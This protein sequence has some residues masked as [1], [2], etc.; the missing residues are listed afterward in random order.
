MLKPD[1]RSSWV[2]LALAA[3]F[4]PFG[5]ARFAR[6]DVSF[7]RDIRPILSENCFACHGHDDQKRKANLRLD[8][9][10]TATRPAKSGAIAIVPGKLDESELVKRITAT[11]PDDRM[12]PADSNKHLT[13]A[14]IETLKQWIAQGAKYQTHWAFVP[15][16]R[17][18]LPAISDPAWSGN[19]IDRLIRARLDAE[20]LK[21]SPQAD[22]V[23]LLRRVYLDLIG[24]PPTVKEIDEH[25]RDTSPD[26][27]DR[28]V[29]KLLA[30]PHYGERM[31]RDWLDAARYADTD[32]FEKDKPRFIWF[33]RDWVINA[34]NRDLPY[35]KF[36]IEQ[37]AGDQL[38]HPMQDQI[39]ATGFL[40]N[41]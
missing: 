4:W 10:E 16:V 30:S 18:P 26:A 32:G 38:P 8:L 27:Y 31:G 20:N 23:T 6:A 40:R 37:I 36:I 17:P 24:L 34:F 39:V 13:A 29:E 1:Y 21:P 5:A 7:N 9:S 15:P 14:Q 41:S 22:K 33:Y 28:V 3:C 2:C 35:D 19:P 12:P 25:L 11:N